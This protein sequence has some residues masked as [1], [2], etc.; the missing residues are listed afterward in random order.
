MGNI[1]WNRIK[2]IGSCR[3]SSEKDSFKPVRGV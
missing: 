2:S 3:E 1:N